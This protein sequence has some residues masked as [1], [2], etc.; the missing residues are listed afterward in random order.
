MIQAI[1]VK[2]FEERRKI[3]YDQENLRQDFQDTHGIDNNTCIFIGL[4]LALL[5]RISYDDMRDGTHPK[6]KE[7]N[8][9][10]QGHFERDQRYLT[11]MCLNV[12]SDLESKQPIHQVIKKIATRMMSDTAL[13]YVSRN[14]IW[15]LIKKG[16][17]VNVIDN[18]G[19]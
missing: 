19:V 17:D 8:D 13:H 3:Y 15:A 1:E 4:L 18:E 5:C 2:A 14:G 9:S 10:I 11:Q 6:G 7:I 12:I 16:A